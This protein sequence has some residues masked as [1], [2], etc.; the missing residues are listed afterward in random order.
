L[1]GGA[2]GADVAVLQQQS[3]QPASQGSGL[4]RAGAAASPGACLVAR[5]QRARAEPEQPQLPA[6]EELVQSAV[7]AAAAAEQAAAGLQRSA[8]PGLWC[9]GGV[10][11]PLHTN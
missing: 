10:L 2:L 3:W 4:G 9:C 7:L 5:L 8:A 6:Q 11:A 1:S